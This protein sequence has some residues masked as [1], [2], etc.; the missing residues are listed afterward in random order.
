MLEGLDA[1]RQKP[2]FTFSEHARKNAYVSDRGSNLEEN[3]PM[4]YE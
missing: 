2:S 3:F 4:D 1:G